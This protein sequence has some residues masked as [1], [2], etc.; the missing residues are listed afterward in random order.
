MERK[1]SK[2]IEMMLR[3]EKEQSSKLKEE[4][5]KLKI[6]NNKKTE[7]IK[8]LEE[9]IENLKSQIKSLKLKYKNSE[10]NLNEH[11]KSNETPK[12]FDFNKLQE[13]KINYELKFIN[14]TEKN[15]K[16]YSE[17]LT[18]QNLQKKY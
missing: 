11:I 10:K 7:R 12:E 17:F 9:N 14:L 4:N 16:I 18:Q 6:D 8:D 15:D 1:D 13:E 3:I 5:K 2:D